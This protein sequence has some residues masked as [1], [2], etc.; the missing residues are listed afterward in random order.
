MK[1][2]NYIRTVTVR[3]S[4]FLLVFFAIFGFKVGGFIDLSTI[5]GL[6]AIVWLLLSVEKIYVSIEYV[7]VVSLTAGILVYSIVVLLL[8]GGDDIQIVLRGGRALL[9]TV[10]FGAVFYNI[11]LTNIVNINELSDI[12]LLVLL[13]GALVIFLQ[14]LFPELKSYLGNLYDFNKNFVTLRAF[15]LTTGYDTAG[16]LCV[17]GGVLSAA[18]AFFNVGR[19][20]I[21][22]FTIF[23][24]AVF[25]TS[26]SSMA[27]MMFFS[28]GLFFVFILRGSLSLK[29]FVVG[30]L[31]VGG[32]VLYK[33]VLPL[34][35]ATFLIFEGF[36]S[37]SPDNTVNHAENFSTTS[38]ESWQR[39]MW[40][41][42]DR[43]GSLVFG[44][45]LDESKSDLGYV[46]LIFMLG[47]LGLLSII[48]CYL[49]V[50]YISNR[51]R[52]YIYNYPLILNAYKPLAILLLV[53]IILQFLINVKNMYFF[54]RGYHE[55]III[56]FFYL[57]G[58]S[59]YIRSSIRSFEIQAVPV[60]A[61]FQ[62]S[63]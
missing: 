59:K 2:S 8:N 26:R 27:L 61:Q 62:E 23:Q 32:V 25:F 11:A 31:V 46:K 19:F 33:Y 53:M 14:I 57:L 49:Y 16:Y 56:V 40:V 37:F 5:A 60:K 4:L 22:A 52:R 6:F 50:L 24:G 34:F 21:I 54:T 18:R 48:S 44:N 58:A 1:S 17:Y 36:Q 13:A 30:Y 28:F 20:N 63:P 3:F 39:N 51:L 15:G 10:F 42:P 45:G 12:I 7:F 41:L 9:A 35:L 43:L 29:I 55:L 38:I 47:L